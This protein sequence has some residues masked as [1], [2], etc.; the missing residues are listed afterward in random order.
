[1]RLIV[2][3]IILSSAWSSVAMADDYQQGYQDGWRAATEAVM[4]N[5]DHF[6]RLLEL[7]AETY[8]EAIKRI[9]ASPRR[10]VQ[11]KT[12]VERTLDAVADAVDLYIVL[13]PGMVLTPAPKTP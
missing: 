2:S 3:A 4:R 5:R 6:R 7:P 10:D 12:N 9:Y 1:M 8:D 13:P 11:G